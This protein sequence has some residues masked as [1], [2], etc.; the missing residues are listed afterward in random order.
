MM[1]IQ[2]SNS[3]SCKKG[4]SEREKVIGVAEVSLWRN[5]WN[6]SARRKRKSKLL[7]TR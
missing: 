2:S 1:Q 3:N 6:L 7:C 5:C 4:E